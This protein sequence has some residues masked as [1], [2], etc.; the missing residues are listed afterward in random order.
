[1]KSRHA[2][3]AIRAARTAGQTGQRCNVTRRRYF[4]D[5][6]VPGISHIDTTG[7]IRGDS[8]R[9]IKLSGTARAI[10]ASKISRL[11]G[12]RCYLSRW[13]YFPDGVRSEEHTSELQ[14][15]MYLVCR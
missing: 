1:M 6:V 13:R 3:D 14:S 8:F 9:Q 11:P 7:I 5:G 12:Y 15:P 2:A 4:S 10:R